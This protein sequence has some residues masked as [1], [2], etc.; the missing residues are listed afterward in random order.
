MSMTTPIPLPLLA[1]PTGSS[2]GPGNP[3]VPQAAA[4]VQWLDQ[5]FTAEQLEGLRA[6]AA[7]VIA[8]YPQPRSAL[9][10][11]LYLVQSVQGYVSADGLAFCAE[12]L[13]LTTAQVAG[14]ASFYTMYRRKPCGTYTVGVCTNTLCAVMGGDAIY[15]RLREHLGLAAHTCATQPASRGTHL[16]HPEPELSADGTISLEHLECNAA[17]DYAPVVMVNWEFFDN[18]TPDS[19]VALVEALLAGQ[20][21]LPTRGASLRSAAQTSRVL[22]GFSDG[23]ADEGVGA[24]G[25]SLAGL[26]VAR[27]ELH[28]VD[29]ATVGQPLPPQPH[30][31]EQVA[32]QVAEQVEETGSHRLHLRAQKAQQAGQEGLLPHEQ[33]KDLSEPMATAAQ[34]PLTPDE[35]AADDEELI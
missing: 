28:P 19:A 6:D 32:E 11:L 35:G 22:A 1:S 16:H 10:P 27:G 8:R 9:L 34:S 12:V 4:A 33:A 23:R 7:T 21:P 5:P 13:N 2:P 18:Q 20:P 29:P 25:A 30:E 24:G 3:E 31:P 17:C 26:R 14:V 15:A